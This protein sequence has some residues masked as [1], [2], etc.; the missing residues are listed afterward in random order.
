MELLRQIVESLTVIGVLIAALT[1]FLKINKIWSRRH[2]KDVSES[3]SVSA[4]VM[5][6]AVTIPFLLKFT[7]LEPDAAAAGRYAISLVACVVFFLVGVGVWVDKREGRSLW[8]RFTSAMRSEGDELQSLLLGVSQRQ[9]AEIVMKLMGHVAWIDG[10]LDPREIRVIE[11]LA[12]QHGLRGSDVYR[13]PV[14]ERAD[15]GAV[16]DEMVHFLATGPERDRVAVV[17]RLIQHL[18]R[19][20]SVANTQEQLILEELRAIVAHYLGERTDERG[21]EVLVVPQRSRQRERIQQ[22][23]DGDEIKRRGGGEAYVVDTCYTAPFA[24][25]VSHHYRELGYFSAVSPRRSA[26]ENRMSMMVSAG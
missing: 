24:R 5:S 3:V 12:A 25:E 14:S 20:D 18:V 26:A 2:I 15:F 1:A 17:W 10:H 9:E 7:L 22:M 6:L 21:F 11:T 19:I 13:K 23:M 4:G 8:K 16:R